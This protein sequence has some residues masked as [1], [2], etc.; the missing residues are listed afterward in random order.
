MT[1][2]GRDLSDTVSSL[3]LVLVGIIELGFILV[4]EGLVGVMIRDLAG[5]VCQMEQIPGR[6][7]RERSSLD[8]SILEFFGRLL[9]PSLIFC[10]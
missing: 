2:V 5:T 4:G 1:S 9:I 6:K 8:V 3:D 10:S 7:R